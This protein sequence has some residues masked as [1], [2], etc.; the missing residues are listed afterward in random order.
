[1]RVGPV[2]ISGVLGLLMI[3]LAMIAGF[4]LGTSQA[5]GHGEERTKEAEEASQSI[6][7]G[8]AGIPAA[9]NL[10][11]TGAKGT[12]NP[13]LAARHLQQKQKIAIEGTYTQSGKQHFGGDLREDVRLVR[14]AT[15][16]VGRGQLCADGIPRRVYDVT[17]INVDI[18][19]NQYHD[20][21]PGYMYVLTENIEAVRE[22]ELRNEDARYALDDPGSVTNGLSGDI[23][24]PLAIR[25]NQGECLVV[26]LSNEVEEEDVSFH[27][28]GSSLV[29]SKT[30]EPAS[31]VNPDT[32]VAPGETTS[33]EWNVGTDQ[34][35]GVHQ[36]HSHNHTQAATGLFG[37]VT[38][39]PEGSR[40]LSPY[41]GEPIESGWLAMIED[42]NGPDFRE[43]V[44]VY[45]ETGDGEMRPLNIKEEMI[46]QRDPT[47]HNYLSAGKALNYRSEPFG[48]G[49]RKEEKM[50]GLMDE[51]Q[52]YS[53][54]HNGDPS[55]P[56]PRSYLGDPA[57]WRL[58][59]GGSEV[60]HSHHLH[61]GAIRWRR[62]AELEQD[63]DLFG[64]ANEN[65][66]TNGPIKNPPIQVASNRVDVQSLGPAET[67]DLVI[68]CGSGGCQRT[69]GDF[70]YHCHVVHHYVAGMWAYWRTYN[71]LQV[72]GAKTDTM[73]PLAELPDRK[74]RIVAAVD[75]TQLVGKRVEW[76]GQDFEIAGRHAKTDLSKSRFSLTD[77]V[78]MQLPPR[79]LPGK[80]EDWKEQILAYD[81]SVW[82]WDRKGDLY[83]GEP[84]TMVSWAKYKPEWMGD[85]AGERPVLLFDPA[86]GK[87]AYPGM[88]PHFG[89]RPPFS[90][91]KSPAPFLEPIHRQANGL[92]SAN[93][94]RPGENGPW[95]LCPRE[96]ASPSQ[97]KQYN[98]HAISTPITL[99]EAE[100][101]QPAIID[102]LGQ[103][104]VLHEEEEKIRAN[105]D[106]KIPLVVRMNVH[107]CVDVVL[108]NE[109]PDDH[110]N[111]YSSKVNMHIHFV[112]FDVQASDGVIT[113]MNYEQSVRPFTI[114]ED[115]GK[116]MGTPQNTL[117]TSRAKAG[118]TSVKVVDASIYQPGAY[119]GV[120]MDAVGRLDIRQIEKISG[121]KLVFTEPLEHKHS[122]GEFVSTEFVR[123]RWFADSD[124]GITYWHDH[125]YGLT[126][127]GHGLFGS[128]IIEPK[129]STYHDPATGEPVRSG[130]IVDIHTNE[131]VS[132]Q[133]TGS[134]REFVM[135]IQDSNPITET[136]VIA[137]AV[138][139]KKPGPDAVPNTINAL[140]SMDSW[141]L[142]VNAFSYLNGGDRTS[143]GSIGLRA[144]P[145]HRR[146]NEN[147]DPSLLFS[148]GAHGDPDT[149][150]L[151]AYLGDPIVIRAL[152]E[153]ANESHMIHVQGH[154]FPI[155][156]FLKGSRPLS[157]IHVAIAERYD[158]VIPAA[159]GPQKMAGDYMYHSG[160]LSHFGE[161]MWGLIRVEDEIRKGLMPLP[162]RREIPK[163]AREVCPVDAPTKSFDVAAI[164]FPLDLNPKA[165]DQVSAPTGTNRNLILANPDGKIYALESEV[166][167]LKAGK[168]QPH[169]LTLRANIGDCI[170]VTLHNRMKSEKASFHADMLAYDPNDSMGANIGR[171]RGDQTVSPGGKRAYTFYAHPEFGEATAMVSDYGNVTRNL[172][173]GLYGS[174]IIGPR[175]SKYRDPVT[176]KD[177]SLANRWQ[178]DVIVDR[179]LR[180]NR[181]RSDY[182]DAALYFQEEDNLI[183]TSF[184]P[185]ISSS[186]GLSAVNYRIEPMAWRAETYDCPEEDAAHCQGKAPDPVT[187]LIEVRAGTAVRMHVVGAHGEQNSTFS[188]EGHQWP[189]EPNAPGAELLEVQQFGPTDTLELNFSAGGPHAIAGDYM[190]SSERMPYSI[191]GQWG[192]LRVLPASGRGHHKRT[193]DMNLRE[194]ERVKPESESVA[195]D[196]VQP[197]TIKQTVSRVLGRKS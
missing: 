52:S 120:G 62:Q 130:N 117:T 134:F 113:G 167:A 185:Y 155:E 156:R 91:G 5:F 97:Q 138:L 13:N 80:K 66:A 64:S 21:Y 4:L 158:L 154:Y 129:G 162:M 128:T 114:L 169:P 74:G 29:V 27:L 142:P 57:K 115:E 12:T 96:S 161:G 116:G 71:T 47:A 166:K 133:V 101:N 42:P 38:V 59:H 104:Y 84:E 50:F 106:L 157:S 79:G 85:K 187:P 107:D 53:A 111:L 140:G 164:D 31:S 41:T 46:S 126:S 25:V 56:I 125:V 105:D 178:A 14:T 7:S 35:E 150:L 127:W 145:L 181:S 94:A 177:I 112:Q 195:R 119:V 32:N 78:E 18:T 3:M 149:P 131:A 34:Q 186:A 188:L 61:G 72:E 176:G 192:I 40:H 88:R 39:E 81:S 55:T 90:P 165:P 183:G 23:I 121:N 153:A 93:V 123:Y 26:K 135:Q 36:V 54:Y 189:L 49:L 148:S 48:N 139:N 33:F 82:N 100:G 70:L 22:S 6:Y 24:Q 143:G 1:M 173:D 65:L 95:S 44:V 83:L 152:A 108:S 194:F 20:F 2:G 77:W 172:R 69:A 67:H 179:S 109:I 45:H 182:R 8:V 60:F 163:S 151:E 75:S 190:W 17:A 160:R 92:E 170:K 87:R 146:L 30:G 58:V 136:Q 175:G 168:K 15:D 19:L 171:N 193:A 43:F 11:L 122:K 51:S 147:D 89:K 141:S 28:H 37:T 9:I 68:E 196:Q 102:P 184:M 191:A 137:G 159:G 110:E 98:I 118:A 86:T 144:E 132:A 174:I 16:S 73:P 124:F 99:S 103:L 76:F 63:L 180:G 10:G 197:V